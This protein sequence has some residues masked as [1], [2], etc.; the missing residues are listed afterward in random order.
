MALHQARG[1][2]KYL[3]KIGI[4]DPQKVFH[5]FRSTSNDCLKQNGVAEESRC[6]F[7]G[8]E[9]D[10]VNSTAYSN[11]HNLEYLLTNVATKLEY[12]ALDFKPLKYEAGQFSEML[13]KLCA[14]KAKWEAHKKAKEIR[15]KNRKVM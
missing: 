2:G 3:D 7:I 6:Q 9:H 15:L 14:K 10:T 8:H 4:T 12:P 13:S 11:P 1:G 5:S